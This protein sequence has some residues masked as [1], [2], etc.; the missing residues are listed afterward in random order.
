MFQTSDT[1]P[2]L[3]ILDM[4]FERELYLTDRDGPKKEAFKLHY[5]YSCIHC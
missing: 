1:K 3:Y 2:V 5:G 4:E